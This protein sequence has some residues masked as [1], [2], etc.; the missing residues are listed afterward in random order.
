MTTREPSDPGIRRPEAEILPPERL[1]ARGGRP[2]P[3][4]LFSI[5]RRRFVIAKPS[6][7]ALILTWLVLGGIAVAAA[8]LLFGALVIGAVTVGVVAGAVILSS[9]VRGA[10]RRFG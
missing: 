5:N 1:D 6:P 10:L 8:F 2:G 7:L 4:I 9:L 3:Q